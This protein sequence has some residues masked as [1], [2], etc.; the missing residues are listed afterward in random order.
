VIE[1]HPGTGLKP[2]V[3]MGDGGEADPVAGSPTG[4]SLESEL[5]AAPNADAVLV[6]QQTPGL[7]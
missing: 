6:W 4:S 2:H 5:A 3:A 1:Q 7:N